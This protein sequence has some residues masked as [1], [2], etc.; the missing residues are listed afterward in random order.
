MMSG[1]FI[2]SCSM[3]IDESYHERTFSGSNNLVKNIG[4]AVSELR[5]LGFTSMTEDAYASAI[6]SLLKVSRPFVFSRI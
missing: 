6:F 1:D 2:R 3:D 5:S 4:K